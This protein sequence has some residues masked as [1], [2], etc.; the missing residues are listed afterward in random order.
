MTIRNGIKKPTTAQNN[1]LDS[2]PL[3]GKC[4]VLKHSIHHEG[5]IMKMSPEEITEVFVELVEHYLEKKGIS[6]NKLAAEAGV[7]GGLLSRLKNGTRKTPALDRVW[8]IAKALDM[9]LYELVTKLEAKEK[10]LEK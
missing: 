2:D 1:K 7:S 8:N 4:Y 5:E 3:H 10:E 9:P 6:Q